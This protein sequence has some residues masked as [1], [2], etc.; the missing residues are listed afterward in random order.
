M[1]RR[2][3]NEKEEGKRRR[4]KKGAG[5]RRRGTNPTPPTFSLELCPCCVGPAPHGRSTC[6]Y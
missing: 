1:E 2:G 4:K 6:R 5:G 3:E